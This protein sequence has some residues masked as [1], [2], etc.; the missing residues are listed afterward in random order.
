[1]VAHL[2]TG[3]FPL[4]NMLKGYTLVGRMRVPLQLFDLNAGIVNVQPSVVEA[5]CSHNHFYFGYADKSRPRPAEKIVKYCSLSEGGKLEV[6]VNGS[7]QRLVK[8]VPVVLPLPLLEG[9]TE[10][11][12]NRHS[13]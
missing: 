6:A 7:P 3:T 11:Q 4:N 5:F 10:V 12:R 1:M 2:A 13:E 8:E 9:K